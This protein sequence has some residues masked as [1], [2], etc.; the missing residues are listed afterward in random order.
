[1]PQFINDQGVIK[2]TKDI[3]VNDQGVV[4]LVKEAWVNDAGTV[5]QYF[6]SSGESFVMVPGTVVYDQAAYTGYD[7]YN[8]EPYG[9]LTPNTINGI[10]IGELNI[11][12]FFE[13]VSPPILGI[14]LLDPA[15]PADFWKTISIS[16]PGFA[17]L[18]FSYDEFDYN[19]NSGI[20][21]Y[22]F[23]DDNPAVPPGFTVDASYD[24]T[25]TL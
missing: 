9:T 19:V 7:H 5:K 25:F 18:T 14:I 2:E 15:L 3:H 23:M 12:A 24:I 13:P 8:S 10:E 6:A 20:Y 4:K 16:G 1:M 21:T 22:W 17:G 11:L